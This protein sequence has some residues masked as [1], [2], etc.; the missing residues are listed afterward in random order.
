M[1]KGIMVMV[2]EFRLDGEVTI[3]NKRCWDFVYGWLQMWDTSSCLVVD[4]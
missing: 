2:L 1:V 3:N 4:L